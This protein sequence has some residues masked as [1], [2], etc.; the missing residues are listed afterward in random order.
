MVAKPLHRADSIVY[1]NLGND[2]IKLVITINFHVS[3]TGLREHE[4]TPDTY[5]H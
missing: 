3:K 4:L 5:F 2:H 1:T